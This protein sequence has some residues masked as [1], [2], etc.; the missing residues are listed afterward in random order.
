MRKLTSDHE[1]EQR[2]ERALSNLMRREPLQEGTP[3][4]AGSG[5]S[6]TGKKTNESAMLNAHEQAD[7]KHSRTKNTQDN[8][9]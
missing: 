4:T 1:E 2:L 9:N 6:K 3:R 5:G 8:I 7:A